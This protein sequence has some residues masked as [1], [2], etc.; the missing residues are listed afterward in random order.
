[1]KFNLDNL[2]I[3]FFNKDEA[4]FLGKLASEVPDFGTIVEVG[5]FFGRSSVVIARH[6]KINVK[7]VCIDLFPRKIKMTQDTSD[8]IDADQYPKLGQEFNMFLEFRKNTEAY[9]NITMIVGDSPNGISYNH[10]P[11]DMFFLDGLHFNPSDL[12]NLNFFCPLVKSGGIICGHDYYASNTYPD[13]KDNVEMLE[14]LYN[15]K[16][17]IFPKTS[18]WM[19]RKP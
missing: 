13:V 6:A 14:K 2:P 18:L 3:G 8:Y 15:K 11:I 19:I 16:A 1:M 5:S 7:I 9:K 17:I 12:D 4:K 10:G